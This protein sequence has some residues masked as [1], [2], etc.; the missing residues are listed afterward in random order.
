[1]RKLVR[2]VVIVAALLALGVIVAGCKSNADKVNENLGKECEKFNCQRH[3]I[4]INGITDKVLLDV[5]GRCSIETNSSLNGA[6]ELICKYGP[7]DYRKSFVGLSDNVT[8]TSVQER[9]LKVS[10]YRTKFIIRPESIV[11]DFDLV[12]GQ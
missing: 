6:L 3:I 8:W 2:F 4:A 10:E 7:D 5:E 11:P 1:M 9:G 12:T